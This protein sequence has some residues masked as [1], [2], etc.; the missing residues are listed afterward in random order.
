MVAAF[1]NRA[2]AGRQMNWF[3]KFFTSEDD[4]AVDVSAN[5]SNNMSAMHGGGG[6][7]RAPTVLADLDGDKFAGGFGITKL[8]TPDYWMLR[9]R[10]EQLFSEN[11]YARGLIRRLI[12]NEINTG[13][14]PEAC[15]DES[16]IGVPE[17]SLN[18]WT[19]DVENRFLLW[20]KNATQCDHLE[21]ATF[22]AIQRAARMEAFITGDVLVLIRP[23]ATTGLPRIQLV[24]GDKVK[25]PMGFNVAAGHTVNK[26]V[27]QNPVGRVVAFWVRQLS[28]E[29][30]R[31]P[32]FSPQTGRKL[33][34]L[35]YGSERRIDDVRG[36]PFLSLILQSLKEVD[37]YRDAAQRKAVINSLIA[38]F[39]EKT[40]DKIGS[41]PITAGATRRGSATVTDG[42]GEARSFN[43]AN[44]IPGMVIEELQQGEKPV[45]Q[46]GQGIDINFGAFEEAI[47]QAIAWTHEVP[48]E[49]LKLAFSN[50]YSASQAAINEFK[51]YLNKVWSDWG[52]TFCQPIYTDWLLAESLRQRIDAP[53]LLK[54]WR[55]PDQHDV[56]GAWI[57][58][59]WYGSIKPSTDMVKQV[60]GSKLLL[61][62]GLS[63]HAR[64][65]RITTGTKFSK[66]VK[67]LKRENEMLVEANKVLLEFER[68]RSEIRRQR[69]G[70]SSAS[71]SEEVDDLSL[72]DVEEA[73]ADALTP[74]DEEAE[75]LEQI[76]N[77]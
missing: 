38:L 32:A 25:T 11:I 19:E 20:G 56:F 1:C 68:E 55:D 43:I 31:V 66:N 46:G 35:I 49:I 73:L 15:P 36:V 63:T 6:V 5:I 24:R 67:R 9:K 53:G 44:H 3:T 13:L 26:G 57:S 64:E 51:I 40:E 48:P 34:W 69:T 76:I 14:T 59:D 65:S 77:G 30:E 37:R 62:E 58:A 7:G 41:N 23:S 52:E 22:G 2:Q 39:I 10:S 60:K 61:D 54:A 16:I 28:G 18:D 74:T 47:I 21:A 42:D 12:T 72:L 17:E 70:P 8:F 75:A 45:M 29:F 4:Q 27:E 71:A 50:N 33:A